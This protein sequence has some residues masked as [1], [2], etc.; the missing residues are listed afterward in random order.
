MKLTLND[1]IINN[2][3]TSTHKLTLYSILGHL[4]LYTVHV[5]SQYTFVN[6]HKHL[7]DKM[8]QD[9]NMLGLK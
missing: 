8:Q 9:K 4:C 6:V 5:F 3:V 7:V 2:S 1:S